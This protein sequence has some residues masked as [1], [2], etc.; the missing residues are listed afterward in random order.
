MPHMPTIL[1]E[2]Q[3]N[4][5]VV[6]YH[7]QRGNNVRIQ[8]EAVEDERDARGRL[9]KRGYTKHVHFEKGLFTTNIGE[10]QDGLEKSYAFK[11]HEVERQ[12]VMDARAQEKQLDGLME[13]AEKDPTL[14]TKLRSRLTKIHQA[15][16]KAGQGES[17]GSAE[18][19]FLL[20]PL[21]ETEE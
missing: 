9:M 5:D 13:L 8:L 11:N 10:L 20:P 4:R 21:P 7:H 16:K 15:N 18:K 1:P 6:T 12:D 3:S 19:E 2:N 17:T 14:A